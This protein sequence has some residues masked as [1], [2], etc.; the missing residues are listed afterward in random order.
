MNRT[1]AER[2]AEEWIAAW[3]AHDLE[4]ILSHY[5]DDF[6]M[7]SPAIRKI[8]EE[9]SGTLAGKEAVGRYWAEALRRTPDLRFE[10]LHVLTGV[11]SVTLI[12]NGVRGLSAE[13]FHFNETGKVIRACA[14]YAV[15]G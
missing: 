14:H 6:E 13:V 7:I 8:A 5:T 2:F 15:Q 9:P 1:F 3:N 11:G 12:Y 10:L 4:S